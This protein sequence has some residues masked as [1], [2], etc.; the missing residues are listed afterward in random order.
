MMLMSSFSYISTVASSDIG[1]T[2][3]SVS[4][5]ITENYI[6]SLLST[7]MLVLGKEIVH[8]MFCEC[9]KHPVY[10]ICCLILK[11]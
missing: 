3:W 1:A 9:S 10:R 11:R 8:T 2:V 7:A 6:S 5:S 4:G